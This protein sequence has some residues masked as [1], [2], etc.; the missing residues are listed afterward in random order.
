[1]SDLEP[2]ETDVSTPTRVSKIP[3]WF[4]LVGLLGLA[5][6]LVLAGFGWTVLAISTLL[7]IV[8][9]HELGHFVTAKATGMKATEFFL[10]FG[11][12]LWSFRRGETEYGIKL[13]PLGGYVRIVGFTSAEEVA[14]SDEPRSYINQKF[15]KR[16][17]VSSAGS[18]VHFAL[19]L[20]LAFGLVWGLGQQEVTGATVGA[21]AKFPGASPAEAVGI[22]GGDV[23]TAVNGVPLTDLS[24][25][26]DRLH[27]S[28]GVPVKLTFQHQGVVRTVWVTPVDG[29]KVLIAGKAY[30]PQGTSGFDG[31]YGVIGVAGIETKTT[32][33]PI[34]PWAA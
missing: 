32:T 29:R 33:K 3:S 13:L 17:L 2:G 20:I 11:P 8:L 21:L 19:A 27:R 16:I 26:T 23:I 6:V 4:G 12:R 18:M 30:V 34:S 15:W 31:G 25:L 5:L 24:Q 22:V 10:G 7:T 1:M 14:P 28:V 9:L